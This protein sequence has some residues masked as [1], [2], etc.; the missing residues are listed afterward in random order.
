MTRN[1]TTS[2]EIYS[3]LACP[4]GCSSS[5]GLEDILNPIRLTIEDTESEKLLRA[6]AVI[7]IIPETIPMIILRTPK[8]WTG[9]SIVS[10]KQVEG[11]FR[12]HQ[13]PLVVDI[14]H[15]KHLNI[16][17]KWL[18]SYRP[19]ELFDKNGK[20]IK[21]I[22][23]ILPKGNK[24]M[25][26]N[27]HTNGGLLLEELKIPDFKNYG[28]SVIY[29]GATIK[30]DTTELGKYLRDVIGLNKKNFRIFGPDETTTGFL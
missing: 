11:T 21:E 27:P 2:P 13:I 30:S 26:M 17:E 16:L 14:E 22:R 25:G 9:P 4:N 29:P 20:L 3:Y 7:E 8:G 15:K 12:A 23:D 1:A 18:L 19:E 5:A 6:S 10:G 28:V 24:R